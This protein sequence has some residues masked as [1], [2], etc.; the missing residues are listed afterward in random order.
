MPDL[1]PLP[2]PDT[3]VEYAEVARAESERGELVLRQRREGEG[4]VVLELRAN[5]VFVMDTREVGSERALATAALAV[6]EQPRAVVVGG[7][8]LGFTLREVLTDPR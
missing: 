5:G 1:S 3:E 8:G 7:L 6:V 2:A 4:P